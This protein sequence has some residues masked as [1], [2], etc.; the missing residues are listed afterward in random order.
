MLVSHVR[1]DAGAE[2]EGMFTLWL[3]VMLVVVA[4]RA[5][6]TGTFTQVP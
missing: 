4:S 6:E 2:D 5:G 1:E 3:L